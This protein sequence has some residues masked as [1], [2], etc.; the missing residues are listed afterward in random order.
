MREKTFIIYIMISVLI[1]FF[2]TIPGYCTVFYISASGD[3]QAAGTSPDRPWK[4]IAKANAFDFKNGDTLC[5]KRGD[6]FSDST[7]KNPGVDNFTIK[8]YGPASKPAP[9]LDGNA[10]QPIRIKGKIKNLT[11]RNL[12]ISGQNWYK[13]KASNI[14]IHSVDSVTIDGVV[15]NGHEGGTTSQGKTA[16]TLDQCSGKLEIRNCHLQNWGPA[17]IPSVTRDFMG[18]SVIDM[19]TGRLFIRDNEIYNINADC[20]HIHRCTPMSAEISSNKLYNAGE[21]AIDCKGVENLNVYQ[22]K[23]YRESTFMG[24]GGN[25]GTPH[26]PSIAIHYSPRAAEITGKHGIASHN[27]LIFQNEFYDFVEGVGIAIAGHEDEH[28]RE[29][30]I[31]WNEFR[32]TMGCVHVLNHVSDS[33]IDGNLFFD[34]LKF[35]HHFGDISTIFVNNSGENV[36]IL[37]NTIYSL[38]GTIE[39]G[40]NLQATGHGTLVENNIVYVDIPEPDNYLLKVT[41]WP[42]KPEIGFNTWYNNSGEKIVTADREY[43]KRN[44]YQWELIHPGESCARPKNI[45]LAAPILFIFEE[46]FL[47]Q[48]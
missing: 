4:T 47:D 37:N 7:L 38:N 25:L 29:V 35:E 32:N 6:T 44:F 45:P 39:T 42:T 5:L 10:I 12:N 41:N 36:K 26:Q 2:K 14:Y 9:V 15:G 34:P 21:N 8:D 27:I 11:I 3:D 17:E 13:K 43:T 19:P 23:I 16:I 48:P 40:I 28:V 33:S 22:N 18:L 46:D 1:L 31:Y 20:V 30:Q 24:W